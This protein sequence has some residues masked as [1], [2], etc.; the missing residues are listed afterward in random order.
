MQLWERQFAKS[1][2]FQ[3][4][5]GKG[6]GVVSFSFHMCDMGLLHVWVCACVCMCGVTP[7]RGRDVVVVQCGVDSFPLLREEVYADLVKRC[8]AELL[9][10]P[11]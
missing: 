7:G 10:G 5:P 3:A 6:P 9:I 1:C 4:T 8:V 11:S 2:L